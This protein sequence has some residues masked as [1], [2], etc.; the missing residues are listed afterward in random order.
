VDGLA[1]VEG[2]YWFY[3]LI[4]V[5]FIALAIYNFAWYFCNKI[6]VLKEN[7]F[8]L[9]MF[10]FIQISAVSL[11]VWAAMFI[12]IYRRAD[13]YKQDKAFFNEI[14]A[15]AWTSFNVYWLFDL[16]AHCIFVMKY[17]LV[18]QKIVAQFTTTST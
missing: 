8:H 5:W 15:V 2:A 1:S 12:V 3:G 10:V 17:W 11:A 18:A 6:L 16:V 4:V 13:Q 9:M 14:W 7:K